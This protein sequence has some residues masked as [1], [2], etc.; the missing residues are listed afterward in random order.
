MPEPR[1]P[2]EMAQELSDLVTETEKAARQFAQEEMAASAEA[3]VLKIRPNRLGHL[4]TFAGGLL[5]KITA[6]CQN[7]VDEIRFVVTLMK[8]ATD[9][10]GPERR[11]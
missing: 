7:N 8:G 5:T 4:V 11:K 6:E 2:D 10:A 3:L 9:L 1:D